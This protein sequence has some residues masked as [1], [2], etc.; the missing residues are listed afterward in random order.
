MRNIN[1]RQKRKEKMQSSKN[2]HHLTLSEKYLHS[3]SDNYR[4]QQTKCGPKPNFVLTKNNNTNY[5][6]NIEHRIL[7]VCLFFFF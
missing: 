2:K 5:A 6:A 1:A 4:V 7:T 3:F